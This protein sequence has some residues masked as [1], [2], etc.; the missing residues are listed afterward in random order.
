MLKILKLLLRT[1][2]KVTS[3]TLKFAVEMALFNMKPTKDELSSCMEKVL[4]Y[5]TLRDKFLF[6]EVT[7]ELKKIGVKEIVIKEEGLEFVG[8][9]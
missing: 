9:T 7:P 5:S 8:E 1:R 2:S 6:D 3:Y 4:K